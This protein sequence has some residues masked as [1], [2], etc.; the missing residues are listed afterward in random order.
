MRRSIANECAGGGGYTDPLSP[1][2]RERAEY[3]CRECGRWLRLRKSAAGVAAE[4]AAIPRHARPDNVFERHA[5]RV[6]EIESRM[7]EPILNVFRS[8][9]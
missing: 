8:K 7:P 9:S 4:V 3:R 6:R 5:R 2:A 1:A